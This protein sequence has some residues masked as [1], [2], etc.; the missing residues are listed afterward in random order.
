MH[1]ITCTSRL[2]KL[3]FSLQRQQG[4]SERYSPGQTEI[5]I[6]VFI[7]GQHSMC[8]NILSSLHIVQLYTEILKLFISTTLETVG[9]TA[10]NL[11]DL[12]DNCHPL[13]L[14]PDHFGGLTEQS[15]KQQDI[16]GM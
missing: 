16:L 6:G 2:L 3:V 5:S 7:L 9:V 8:L 15:N 13:G 14:I 12:F 4:S 10:T 1:D 11:C